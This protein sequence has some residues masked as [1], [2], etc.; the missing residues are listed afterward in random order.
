MAGICLSALAATATR[1]MG[2]EGAS[3]R[4]VAVGLDP[5]AVVGRPAELRVTARAGTAPV[6]GLVARFGA[7]DSFGLS[8]CRTDSAG[9]PRAPD[10]FA[11]GSTVRFAVPHVFGRAGAR[12]VLLRLDA[13]GCGTPA[14]ARSS[15]SSC[16]PTRPGERIVPPTILD[17][18]LPGPGVPPLPGADDLPQPAACSRRPRAQGTV[19]GREPAGG[20]LEAGGSRRAQVGPLPHQRPAAPPRAA[21]PARQ[22]PAQAGGRRALARD[23]APAVPR[24]RRPVRTQPRGAGERK[25]RYLAGASSW[26]IGENI[27]Y[28][29]GR[30]G[31]PTGMVRAWMRSSP[32][33][34][35]ILRP[36]FR[37]V[38]I[39]IVRGEPGR[40][41]SR[42][43]TYT[44]DF[45]VRHR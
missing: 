24:P 13:G 12:G 3:P 9:T 17:A 40:R 7:R 45:G 31:T 14:R 11:P 5:P 33:R 19:P 15:R 22:R 37:S 1:P 44:T 29:H 43:A 23:G 8:A 2:A 20:P 30:Y 25:T 16:T 32:H 42:G 38:G 10:P 39:G 27:G 26:S 21:A 35:N 6:S 41:R 18:P 36:R 28:G 4:V 34:A